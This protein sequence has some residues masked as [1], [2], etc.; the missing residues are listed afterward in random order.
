MALEAIVADGGSAP[1]MP[2]A[3]QH[4]VTLPFTLSSPETCFIF[5]W[6]LLGAPWPHFATQPDQHGRLLVA[7]SLGA[8]FDALSTRPRHLRRP[9]RYWLTWSESSIRAFAQHWRGSISPLS[10]P[11][12]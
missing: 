10:P 6:F 12:V 7:A 8:L 1:T 3:F 5:Y 11:P 4:F 2:E 9:A